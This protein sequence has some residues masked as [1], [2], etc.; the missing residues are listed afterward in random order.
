MANICKILG[1]EITLSS[2]TTV[3]SASVVRVMNTDANATAVITLANST[4]TI[5][6]VTLNFAGSDESVLYIAKEP[7]QTLSATGTV[8]AVPVAYI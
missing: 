4:A 2:N 5:A 1:T 6:N 7:S 8:K 3:S